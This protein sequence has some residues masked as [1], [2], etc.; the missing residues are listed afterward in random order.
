MHSVTVAT[1]ALLALL[2]GA[3]APAAALAEGAEPVQVAAALQIAP[4]PEGKGQIVFIRPSKLKGMAVSFSVREGGKAI[5]KLGNGSYFV[6]P[7]DPG[8]HEYNVQS[9][10][11][12]ALHM[13]VEVG[14]TY[15]VQQTIDIGVVLART[16]LTPSDQG[17]FAKLKLKPTAAKTAE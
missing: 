11:K 13:E 1:L 8:P 3:A 15:Y 4:P 10:V 16:Y 5:G 6:L 14:E 9:E 17:E 2:L 7:A 12:D